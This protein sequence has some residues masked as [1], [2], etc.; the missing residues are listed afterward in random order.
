MEDTLVKP[1]NDCLLTWKWSRVVSIPFGMS[2][3]RPGK[4]PRNSRGR[5]SPTFSYKGF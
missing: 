4:I 2:P 5:S 3:E 1:Q